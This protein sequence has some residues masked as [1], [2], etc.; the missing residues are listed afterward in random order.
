MLPA[1][2]ADRSMRAIVTIKASA[3]PIRIIVHNKITLDNPSLLPGAKTKIGG[4]IPSNKYIIKAMATIIAMRDT[5][6]R[7]SCLYFVLD[8]FGYIGNY[9]CKRYDYIGLG[10]LTIDLYDC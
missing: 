8:I 5:R 9:K 1:N 4:I 10:I 6:L 3:T 7:L 2:I